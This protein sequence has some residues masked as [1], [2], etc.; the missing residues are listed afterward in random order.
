MFSGKF[1]VIL[2][3]GRSEDANVVF[4]IQKNDGRVEGEMMAGIKIHRTDSVQCSTLI[5]VWNG[6]DEER[7]VNVSIVG[8]NSNTCIKNKN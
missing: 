1:S 4:A 8:A 2:V 5:N 7:E 3:V 6:R